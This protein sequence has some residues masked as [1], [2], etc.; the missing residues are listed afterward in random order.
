MFVLRESETKKELEISSEQIVSVANA[1]D[2]ARATIELIT[3][4]A[5][6]GIYNIVNSGEC[7]WADFAKE[8][9]RLRGSKMK[10]LAVDRK[11][12]M[13]GMKIP[14]YTVLSTQKINS[15]GIVLPSWRE[16]IKSYMDFLGKTV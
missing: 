9:V 1:N 3:K 12:Y 11:G 13:N 8:I 14:K 10:I 16:G 4:K 15:M 2:L 7:S 6:S 5:E